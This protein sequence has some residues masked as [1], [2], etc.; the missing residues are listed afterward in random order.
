LRKLD[1]R[2][3]ELDVS[4]PD[5]KEKFRS[6]PILEAIQFKALFDSTPQN[7]ETALMEVNDAND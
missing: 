4:E 2:F 7:V 6:A 3:A 5:A 1:K